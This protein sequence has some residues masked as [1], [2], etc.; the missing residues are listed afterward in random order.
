M[1]ASAAQPK[2]GE[3]QVSTITTKDGT[4]DTSKDRLNADLLAFAKSV[5]SKSVS[6]DPK[7]AVHG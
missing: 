4:G 2:Q 6:T 3:K 7:E 1:A 5:R